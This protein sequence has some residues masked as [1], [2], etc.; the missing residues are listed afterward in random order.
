VDR[1]DRDIFVRVK[2]GIQLQAVIVRGTGHRAPNSESVDSCYTIQDLFTL[3]SRYR[4]K[5]A[6]AEPARVHPC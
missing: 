4:E 1:G 3:G 5:A 6:G 2:N